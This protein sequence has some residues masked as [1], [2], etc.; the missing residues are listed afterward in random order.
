[1]NTVTDFTIYRKRSYIKHLYPFQPRNC[2][3]KQ[4]QVLKKK[5]IYWITSVL[6]YRVNFLL[7][8]ACF[9]ITYYCVWVDKMFS[10]KP[11]NFDITKFH[12]CRVVLV[13]DSEKPP[14][15]QKL[16]FAVNGAT[17]VT[18]SCTHSASL[19]SNQSSSIHPAGSGRSVHCLLG[20]LDTNI[21]SLRISITINVSPSAFFTNPNNFLSRV[22]LLQLARHFQK[23]LGKHFILWDS[24]L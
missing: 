12:L 23:I 18:S 22:I 5:I 17:W 2:A 4:P 1:M 11:R 9:L 7:Y 14:P 24:D 15:S 10:S 8:Y 6:M 19:L 21:C 3:L 13:F 16:T 20:F